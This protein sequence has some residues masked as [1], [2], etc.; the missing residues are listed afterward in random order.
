MANSRASKDSGFRPL[1]QSP[2]LLKKNSDKSSEKL[3][4]SPPLANKLKVTPSKRSKKRKNP[5]SFN[6]EEECNTSKAHEITTETNTS[7]DISKDCS[8]NLSFE[9][10]CPQGTS[11]EDDKLNTKQSNKTD[12]QIPDLESTSQD[13]SPK[14]ELN[15]DQS[16][17]SSTPTIL[18]EEYTVHDSSSNRV[19]ENK[20]SID[21]IVESA[22]QDISS[23]EEELKTNQSNTNS[24]PHLDISLDHILQDTLLEDDKLNSSNNSLLSIIFEECTIDDT[25]SKDN[26]LNTNQKTESISPILVSEESASEDTSSKEDELNTNKSNKSSSS[27]S[28]S[29]ESTSQ[30]KSYE[31][32]ELNTDQRNESNT[33]IE[34]LIESTSQNTSSKDDKLN[35]SPG[36]KR[37]KESASENISFK[38]D[39]L[40]INKNS[41][42]NSS[43]RSSEKSASEDT[44]SK[45]DELNTNKSNKSSS[46][47]SSLK[48]STSQDKSY[49]K[50]ELNTDQRNESNTP[51]EGLIESTSQNTSSKD[52]KLNTSPGSKRSKKSALEN[53]SF[54][55]IK[56][57][58]S[59]N[60][61]TN[62]SDRSS[63]ESA[64]E[65]TSSKEDELNTNKSNKSSSS[66]SS[67][68]ES[69]S[70]DTSFDEYELNISKNSTTNSSDLS[71]EESASE[72]SSS[73]EDEL[74]TNKS[75]ISSSS[76]S[77][78]KESTSH[79]TSFDEYELNSSGN[80]TTNSSD[81]SSEESAS[82]DTS[83]KENELNTNKRNISS[84]LSS[85]FKKSTSQGASSENVDRNESDATS[86]SSIVVSNESIKQKIENSKSLYKEENFR[87]TAM[88]TFSITT[89][90]EEIISKIDNNRLIFIKGPSGC[91][92]SM[93][94]PLFIY[95][96][97]LKQNIDCNIIVT[98][99]T[100]IAAISMAK[101]ICNERNW[102][103]GTNVGYHTDFLNHI[104]KNTFITFCTNYVL[105]RKFVK[106]NV[107]R[108]THIILDD[109]HERSKELDIL[110]YLIKTYLTNNSSTVKIILMSAIFNL[111]KFVNY[112]VHD[113]KDI[114]SSIIDFSKQYSIHRNVNYLHELF[115]LGPLPKVSE[116]VTVITKRM[117][118]YCVK[119]IKAIEDF[120]LKILP[121]RKRNPI[122]SGFLIFLPQ[123]QEIEQMYDI[124]MSDKYKK[125]QWKV[126]IFDSSVNIFKQEKL[127]NLQLSNKNRRIILTTNIAEN[128]IKI[129]DI[130]YVI[131]FCLTVQ[132]EIDQQ[133]KIPQLRNVW[134]S[135][136]TCEQ[137]SNRINCEREGYL[138]RLVTRKFYKKI[139]PKESNPEIM[140][141]PLEDI[142]IQ[143]KIYHS[144]ESDHIFSS[145]ID[146]PPPENVK[147]SRL[148]LQEYG[149]LRNTDKN[150]INITQ[151]TV[152]GYLMGALPLE[153]HL[154]KLILLG[155][156]YGLLED[157]II[158]ACCM[159]VKDTF[160]NVYDKKHALNIYFEKLN[161][162]DNSGSDCIVLLNVYKEWI[163]IQEM[164]KNFQEKWT[165]QNFLQIDVLNEV[166]SRIDC[167][168]NK[169]RKFGIDEMNSKDAIK[170]NDKVERELIIKIV[171]AG[172]FYPHY[173]NKC[174]NFEN[175]VCK[176]CVTKNFNEKD[177]VVLENF[178]MKEPERYY[179]R[180]IENIFQRY[181]T[182]SIEKIIPCSLYSQVHIQFGKEIERKI[183]LAV[184]KSVQMRKLKIPFEIYYLNEKFAKDFS[185]DS[186]IYDMINRNNEKM[187]LLEDEYAYMNPILPGIT[188]STVPI[189]VSLFFSPFQFWVHVSNSQIDM[190]M[191]LIFQTLNHE[192]NTVT[193]F[194]TLPKINDLVAVPLNLYGK[195]GSM[196][197]Y[198]AIVKEYIKVLGE[199][200]AR[201]YL[202]DIGYTATVKTNIMMKILKDYIYKIPALAIECVLANIQEN[203]NKDNQYESFLHFLKGMYLIIPCNQKQLYGKIYSVVN[204]VVS[205]TLFCITN[206]NIYNINEM[207]I[208]K[209]YAIVKEE[210]QLSKDNNHV[211]TTWLNMSRAAIESYNKMQYNDKYSDDSYD[212]TK[213]NLHVEK[214][215]CMSRNI[216]RGP[217]SLLECTFSALTNANKF[218]KTI[219]DCN[220]INSVVLD[221]DTKDTYKQDIFLVAGK[222][223]RNTNDNTLI[224]Y[225]TTVIKEK[226]GL[227]VLIALIFSSHL[228]LRRNLRGTYYAGALCGLGFDNYTGCNIFPEHEI[229]IQSNF[230]ISLKDIKCI[231]IL[232]K[233][234]NQ[235]AYYSKDM[236]HEEIMKKKI[237]R[238]RLIKNLL[239]KLL[240]KQRHY[241]K[242]ILLWDYYKWG[243]YEESE[244]IKH[245]DE[246]N[247]SCNNHIYEIH[248]VVNLK[249]PKK[250]TKLKKKL[251][252][253][254]TK[255]ND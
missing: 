190:K 193:T 245:D 18:Y 24:S 16:S 140:K 226:F 219:I 194:N 69:T 105:L 43:D 123:I 50:D 59:K 158:I 152:L 109:V 10:I 23:K 201:L 250:K 79:D 44:S 67:F 235:M 192:F 81:L 47:S 101:R 26:K 146:P 93:H 31:K 177:T 76:S 107:N 88:S 206:H 243:L 111:N 28:S 249:R 248:S 53:I 25:T 8:L 72:D 186:N 96:S 138:Y 199:P 17:R 147:L 21:R 198:R 68:K 233:Y 252:K 86:S 240:N 163:K 99:P 57:N 42:T 48:E 144:D 153:I 204:N 104:S 58:I 60:S 65:N 210:S 106:R 136:K 231:N 234:M 253:K 230:N 49:E 244:I 139:L 29:K 70:H 200:Y 91:G 1:R 189:T 66:S 11:S 215:N 172:A 149:A 188:T 254:K 35:T 145:L 64:S 214:Y 176:D 247:T 51:I 181:F 45:E 223:M 180:Q 159:S 171:I 217:Y 211:R 132:L 73:K 183:P 95:D 3:N 62:S 19:S 103:L 213:S 166:S 225:N 33:L 175:P 203:P 71:S 126:I 236:N 2:R 173:Y 169:L 224:L 208:T 167:I 120:Q 212:F 218:H 34:G 128:S 6:N 13:T 54:K 178:P 87:Y 162:A 164:S 12:S 241:N 39:K 220:S 170:W 77:S 92:K 157:M 112:F 165:K 121:R 150:N 83:S 143:M 124:L 184:Y 222:I 52:D 90:E 115:M 61:T 127:L 239:L 114:S 80:S 37:S 185:K 134:A 15:I 155:Y 228:E 191:S 78:F 232:R 154:T 113:N 89:V 141:C 30:D 216:L 160:F 148:L 255:L 7:K 221:N 94:V 137:R 196:V 74:N 238:P 9:K 22:L 108:Y 46:S 117:M 56:L 20:T 55:M 195:N 116:H 119:L 125:Y 84:S 161:W 98:Q 168:K 182:S 38:M 246:F 110:L 202:I 122:K 102:S 14:K 118:I 207:L 41:T 97:C 251:P 242:N 229:E 197:F 36:S 179:T 142:F 85:S 100:H 63:E 32:D 135:K 156:F 227:G 174:T 4:V 205:L 40:N 131:D 151:L 27:S 5:T 187:N 75:N 130:R 209:T 82:E 133:S 237:I 129:P